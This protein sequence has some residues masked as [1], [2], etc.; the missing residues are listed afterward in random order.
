M[1]NAQFVILFIFPEETFLDTQNSS[2]DFKLFRHLLGNA[3][4]CAVSSEILIIMSFGFSFHPRLSRA[5]IYLSHKPS[6][7]KG[8]MSKMVSNSN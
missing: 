3:Q 1:S 8:V 2:G 5:D 6:G 4:R 7:S